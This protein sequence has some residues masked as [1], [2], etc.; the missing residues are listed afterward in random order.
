VSQTAIVLAAFGV[1]LPEAMA[2]VENVL[3][4]VEAAF[5]DS[6]VRLAFTSNLVRRVWQKRLADPDWLAAHPHTPHYLRAIQ[7]P[8]ATIANLQDQGYQNQII[9]PLHVY[10]GEEFHDLQSYVAG[11]AGIATVKPK[12]RPF[13][14]LALG[15]PAL[16]QPGVIHPYQRDLRRAADIL[17]ADAAEARQMGAALVYVGHGNHYFSTGVFHELRQMLAQDHPDILIEIGMVEGLDG[18]AEAAARLRQAGARRALLK[19]LMLVAGVHAR[20]DM[21][22]PGDDSWR[23]ALEAAGVETVC[24]LEGLGENNAWADIYVQNIR[25]AAEHGGLRP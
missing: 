10:A 7:G 23:G 3:R 12:W 4:R 19:P 20:D 2:G 11:L 14:T 18:P 15:R 24:R 1:S 17:A 22:G 25:D 5:A 9:Q 21:A 8:L 16:G 6:P 13:K